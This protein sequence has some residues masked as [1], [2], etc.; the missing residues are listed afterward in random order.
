ML[1][2]LKHGTDSSIEGL[3]LLPRKV[4]VGSLTVLQILATEMRNFQT[5]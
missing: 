3:R 5:T 4:V 2:V 1:Q